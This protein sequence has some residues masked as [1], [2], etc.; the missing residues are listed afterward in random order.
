MR[1][2]LIA[3][4]WK[5]N[6]TIPQARELVISL[7]PNITH[8]EVEVVLAP[9]FT[10]LYSVRELIKDT[11]VNLGAQDLF[12]EEK[13]AFTG[14]ISAM[15]LKDIGC[16][17]VIVGHSERRQYFGETDSIVNKKTLSS[18]RHSL[19]PILCI[20]E[21][22]EERER[23]KTFD[24]LERELR[25]GLKGLSP[26]T[27][28]LHRIVIAYEPVWAI[29]TGKTATPK[30]ANEAHGFIRGWVKDSFGEDVAL[31]L[32]IIYGG[33][34]T[35]ENIDGLMAQPEVDGVLVG[36]ASLKAEGFARI[37]N[38]RR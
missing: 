6:M 35:P 34:V 2:P 33:S 4:N 3:G 19:S 12:W 28:V 36:G 31:S 16:S 23:G 14:E 15:M 27:S 5:M 10:A 32:R 29:G 38:F 26:E 18:L 13:G 7:L 30:Q 21:L 11:K 37:V 22:L 9:P 8:D 24:V 1:I 20:G 17:Y 25:E